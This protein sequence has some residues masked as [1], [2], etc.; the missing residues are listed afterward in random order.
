MGGC[1]EAS[2]SLTFELEMTDSAREVPVLTSREPTKLFTNS[3]I[4]FLSRIVGGCGVGYQL[5]QSQLPQTE[6]HP[7]TGLREKGVSTEAT[8]SDRERFLVRSSRDFFRAANLARFA[9]ISARRR[10]ARDN[11]PDDDDIPS[12]L[13]LP[14]TSSSGYREEWQRERVVVRGW[15]TLRGQS[16]NTRCPTDRCF[17]RDWTD[18]RRAGRS[19]QFART[20]LAFPCYDGD[21]GAADTTELC[22]ARLNR[23]DIFIYAKLHTNWYVYTGIA[24]LTIQETLRVGDGSAARI[25]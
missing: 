11:A 10:S 25:K 3:S 21:H 14:G 8:R 20:F 16:V 22:F 13:P 1:V 4:S 24:F 12:G 23:T 7:E 15:E 5:R 19:N 6:P 9:S 17:E 18:E 2:L